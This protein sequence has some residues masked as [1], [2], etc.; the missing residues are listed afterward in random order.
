MRKDCTKGSNADILGTDA[1]ISAAWIGHG[2]LTNVH[3]AGTVH[4]LAGTTEVETWT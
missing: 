4:A 1:S 2:Q 3:G